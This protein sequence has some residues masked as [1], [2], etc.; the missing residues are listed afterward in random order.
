MIRRG[1]GTATM[2]YPIA[3][4]GPS[5]CFFKMDE[6]GSGVLYTG[7][8][9]IGQGSVTVLKQLVCEAM[10]LTLEKVEVVYGDSKMAPYDRGPV[11]SRTTFVTGNAV[12]NACKE[13]QKML[14]AAAGELLRVN[15]KA[16]ETK[17]NMIYVRNYEEGCVS[18]AKAASYALNKK[19]T[20]IVGCGVYDP[21]I[22]PISPERGHGK[23]YGT[24][25]FATQIAVVDVDDE[26]GAYKVRKIYAAHDC[27]VAI[28]PM[29]VEGQIQG[30]TAQGVGFASFEEMVQKEGKVMN[31]QFT[32]YIVPTMLDTPTIEVGIV[33]RPDPEGPMGAKG[34]GEPAIMPTAPAI[35]NAIYD[36]VGV[37]ITDLPI[38]PE[39]VFMALREK[40]NAQKAR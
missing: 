8:A 40:K 1:I 3:P 6:D 17:D 30:A 24:H 34:V 9:D 38:T 35:A 33:E 25:A 13:A 23:Q 20:P 36:A 10:G 14:Y 31:P 12:L 18:V 26:T 22:V 39:K 5:A 15:P 21:Y 27:G 11:G 7:T 16:L 2:F 19:G 37:R 4:A 28:N 29:F 32:D